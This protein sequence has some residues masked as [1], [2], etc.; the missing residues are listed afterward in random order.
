MP[1]SVSPAPSQLAVLARQCLED[2]DRWF[3]D[4]QAPGD[5]G[6][7]VLALCG[8]VGELANYV[9]K[10]QRRSLSLSDANTRHDVV[11][12][13]ADIFTYLLNIA[14]IMNIDLERVYNIKRS[15]NERRFREQREWR[16]RSRVANH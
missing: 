5:L 13:V 9:K 8:E 10:V 16:E 1:N 7:H 12:E 3:G 14:G 11:M 2:S 15:E 4:T 6:H